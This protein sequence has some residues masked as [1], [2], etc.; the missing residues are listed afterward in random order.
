MLILEYVYQRL[1]NILGTLLSHA[2]SA[3]SLVG[4][5]GGSHDEVRTRRA[6]RHPDC[7][8][9]KGALPTVPPVITPQCLLRQPLM[10]CDGSGPVGTD[11]GGWR[12][13]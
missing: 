12:V 11:D 2:R 9:P 8:L 7:S 5:G 4:G 6:R 1:T 13:L 10:E 3:L